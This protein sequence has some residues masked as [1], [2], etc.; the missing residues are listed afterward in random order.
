M[1]RLVE[2]K[3][4]GAKAFGGNKTRDIKDYLDRVARYVPAEILTPIRK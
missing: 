2:A 3:P 4:R 1:S